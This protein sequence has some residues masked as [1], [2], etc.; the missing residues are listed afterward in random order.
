MQFYLCLF[1]VYFSAVCT[2]WPT[3][4]L[5]ILCAIPWRLL[6]RRTCGTHLGTRDGTPAQTGGA[7]ITREACLTT[8]RRSSTLTFTSS[9]HAYKW[10]FCQ[11][12]GKSCV[13]SR[14]D[15]GEFCALSSISAFTYVPFLWLLAY[16]LLKCINMHIHVCTHTYIHTHVFT[17]A[18]T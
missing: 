6:S 10:H 5:S 2:W 17:C 1:S 4:V 14:Q 18:R 15:C 13:H 9:W 8:P 12:Y 7:L 11:N 3:R 16:I